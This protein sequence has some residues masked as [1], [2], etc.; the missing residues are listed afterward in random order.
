M[1]D[2]DNPGRLPKKL[3]KRSK[4][5]VIRMVEVRQPL[6]PLTNA[7]WQRSWKTAEAGRYYDWYVQLALYSGSKKIDSFVGKLPGKY[8]KAQI[9]RPEIFE[10]A[11]NSLVT[12][13]VVPVAVSPGEY[14]AGWKG[15]HKQQR[16]PGE[17][18][19]ARRPVTKIKLIRRFRHR[20]SF[21]RVKG[22]W[23]RST[24]RIRRTQPLTAAEKRGRF[25]K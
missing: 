3:N 18:P 4:S 6:M 7:R 20:D 2:E 15:Y 8:T 14:K 12:P 9:N 19:S 1:S 11:L 5:P 23:K 22:G 25:K 21:K 13:N 16:K 10:R 17:A 24:L